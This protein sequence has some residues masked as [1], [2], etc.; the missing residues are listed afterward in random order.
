MIYV[1]KVGENENIYG[2]YF[3][4]HFVRELD[5]EW[6]APTQ[7]SNE[8]VLMSRGLDLFKIQCKVCDRS[9]LD[10]GSG[11]IFDEFRALQI[12]IGKG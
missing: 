10:G 12:E 4:F 2:L 3:R 7:L 6:G 8:T 11:R 1:E 5:D 9:A